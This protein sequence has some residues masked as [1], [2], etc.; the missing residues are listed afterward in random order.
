MPYPWLLTQPLLVV[1]HVLA[2]ISTAGVTLC[3][4]NIALKA[5]PRGKATAYLAVNA[6]VGGLAA[7][8]APVLAGL[9]ADAVAA[10]RWSFAPESLRLRGLDFVFLF[11][12][13]VGLVALTRLRSV[14]EEGEIEERIPFARFWVESWKVVA[15]VSSVGGLRRLTFFPYV[16]LRRWRPPKETRA[17]VTASPDDETTRS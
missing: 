6:L 12:V 5:S 9:A 7:T 2:G 11:S 15:R 8:A 17:G 10:A 1:I 4:T 13:V 3:T 16:L 14:T